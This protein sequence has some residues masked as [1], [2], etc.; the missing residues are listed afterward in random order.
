M[1]N[2]SKGR[3]GCFI[4]FSAVI[5]LRIFFPE[6]AKAFW[7]N[8]FH[9]GSMLIGALVILGLLVGLIKWLYEKILDWKEQP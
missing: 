6:A 4:F 3:Y 5:T 2:N 8:W 1:S 7:E 9:Q